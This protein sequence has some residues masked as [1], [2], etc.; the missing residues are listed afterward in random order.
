VLAAFTS[1][2]ASADLGSTDQRYLPTDAESRVAMES[3]DE[4]FPAGQVGRIHV[5]VVG[6]T[7]EEGLE[8]YV[9]RLDALPG[10]LRTDI[11]RTGEDIAH[12]E[13]AYQG[14]TDDEDVTELVQDVRA[15]PG[16]DG[17][18]ATLVGGVAAMQSGNLDAIVEAPPITATLVLLFLAFGSVVLP[19]KAVLIGAMSLGASLGVVIWGFQDGHFAGLLGFEPI[20][21]I[22]PTYL[23]LI[24]LVSFGLA[25]DYELFLLSRV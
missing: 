19:I 1:G 4:D 17:A 23:V 16:P 7:T 5:A 3:M 18:E 14:Q 21:T 9:E 11:H 22:D 20:G 8:E 12:I 6:S 13:I 15:E 2:L 24:L 25:M 10:A